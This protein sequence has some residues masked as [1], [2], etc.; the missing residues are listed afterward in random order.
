MVLP[1]PKLRLHQLLR[2]AHQAGENLDERAVHLRAAVEV[3]C[4]PVKILLTGQ[5]VA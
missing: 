4:R 5:E 1:E 2:L 3:Q